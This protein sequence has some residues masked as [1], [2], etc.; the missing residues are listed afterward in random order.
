MTKEDLEEK[1]VK[2][3]IQ[4]GLKELVGRNKYLFSGM[5]DYL[6]SHI[7]SK[8]IN[9]KISEIYRTMKDKK[10]SKIE[11]SNFL[12][13]HLKKY[14]ASGSM[15]DIRGEEA[16]LKKGLEEKTEETGFLDRIKSFFSYISRP[17]EQKYLEK[18][19]KS[20]NALYESFASNDLNIDPKFGKYMKEMNALYPFLE[21]MKEK[22]MITRNEVKKIYREAA[23]N[24]EKRAEE[25]KGGLE[26]YIA[27][28]IAA[29][30]LGVGGIFLIITSIR[31]TGA[32]IGILGSPV[33]PI[34]GGGMI[35]SSLRLIFN[36]L[37][38]KYKH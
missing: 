22:K 16:M 23:T 11:G 38:K 25:Y 7:D 33:I 5:E 18:T 32:V 9:S 27:Q 6:N 1:A 36:I 37:R 4:N 10:M 13:N 14:I 2:G 30:I 19:L 17:K 26:K 29:A 28:K 24:I 31:I 3:A 8:K 15:F 12:Y 34:I 35:L 21:L 20:A